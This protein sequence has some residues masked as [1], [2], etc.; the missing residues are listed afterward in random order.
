MTWISSNLEREGA[1]KLYSVVELLGIDVVWL[2]LPGSYFKVK[3]ATVGL[4]AP[5]CEA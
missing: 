1:E 4:F 5:S 3:G 2:C